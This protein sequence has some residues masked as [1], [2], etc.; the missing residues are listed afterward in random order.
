VIKELGLDR[1][2][3]LRDTYFGNYSRLLYL[4]QENSAE[5]VQQA[6]QAADRLDLRFEQL[7]TGFGKLA[8]QIRQFVDSRPA[9]G[10]D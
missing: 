5:L 10:L 2:P 6:R 8:V 7:S 4:S 1:H 9:R 3:H